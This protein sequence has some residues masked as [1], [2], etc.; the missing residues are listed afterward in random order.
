VRDRQGVGARLQELQ[1]RALGDLWLREPLAVEPF[2]LFSVPFRVGQ[3]RREEAM[4]SGG[5]LFDQCRI[6]AHGDELERPGAVPGLV[7]PR[8]PHPT[9]RGIDLYSERV[10]DRA[11]A[12]DP[13]A[14]LLV[15]DIGGTK[16]DLAVVSARGG[17]RERLAYR[18]YPNREYDCL[19]DIVRAFSSEFGG[20]EVGAACFDVA[21]PV[22]DG[23]ARLTN[24]PWRLDEAGLAHDLGLSH[25]WLVNDLVA[26][27]AAVPLL[28]GDELDVVQEGEALLGGAIAVL[29][30][31]TGLGEAFLTLDGDGYRPQA[32]E[33]GHSAFSPAG[34][35]ELELLRHLW[36]RFDHVSVERIASGIGIPNVYEFLRDERGMAESPA[37]AVRLGGAEDRTYPIIEA[38]IDPAFPDPL[39]R[40]TVDL[41]LQVLGTEAANLALKVLA[42]GGIFLA[43]GIAQRL[44]ERL[45]ASGFLDALRRSGRFRS[46]LERVPVAVVKGEVALLGAASVGLRLSAK[47]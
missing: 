13:N 2:P 41:F 20:L 24:L 19:Q 47:A 29:A 1:P 6:A 35:L 34:E 17:P 33:G 38:A 28:R 39:A 31:G 26:T 25:A 22:V 46:T 43:G 44:R 7:A 9:R 16:T 40:A 37:L 14:L 32:S 23:T 30:P 10:S 27:A 3:A 4:F 36:R 21:G 45:P 5:V 15:G 11:F 18:R 42:T 12:P 8:H